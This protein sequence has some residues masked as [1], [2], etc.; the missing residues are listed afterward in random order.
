MEVQTH[1]EVAVQVKKESLTKRRSLQRG[2]L[3][4]IDDLQKRKQTARRRRK[5]GQ[6]ST[7]QTK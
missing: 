5:I 2:S 6:N 4:A 3:L 1:G 7:R